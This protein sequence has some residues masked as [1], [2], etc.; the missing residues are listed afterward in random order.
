M[1]KTSSIREL[2]LIGVSRRSFE[3]ATAAARA[4]AVQ[5]V[6]DLQHRGPGFDGAVSASVGE[7]T[8]VVLSSEGGVPSYR[9][10]LRVVIRMVDSERAKEQRATLTKWMTRL[11]A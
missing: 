2:E 10:H 9:V 1:N 6:T 5:L 3:R 4:R 7:V 8:R 11:S